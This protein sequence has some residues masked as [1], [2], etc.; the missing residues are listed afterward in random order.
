MTGIDMI[1]KL[2]QSS[3]ARISIMAGSGITVKTVPQIL[4]AQESHEIHRGAF[5]TCHKPNPSP[6]W[7]RVAAQDRTQDHERTQVLEE[8]VRQLKVATEV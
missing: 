5:H 7:S 3:R 2:V 1:A 6:S 4:D 8:D